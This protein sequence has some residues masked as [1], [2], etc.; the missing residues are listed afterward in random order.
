MRTG[1]VCDW[2][3]LSVNVTVNSFAAIDCAQGVRH[4]WPVEVVASAPAGSDSNCTVVAGGEPNE[5]LGM[6]GIPVHPA[7]L[8]PHAAMATVRFMVAFLRDRASPRRASQ[9]QFRANVPSV[10]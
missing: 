5:K 9:I 8:N 1:T 3:P 7:R 6:L 10:G 4:V 2:K